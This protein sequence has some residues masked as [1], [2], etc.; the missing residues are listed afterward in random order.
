M[1][2]QGEENC[3]PR[4]QKSAGKTVTGTLFVQFFG[5][6]ATQHQM[7]QLMGQREALPIAWPVPSDNHNRLALNMRSQSIKLLIGIAIDH[8]NA[9]TPGFEH[10]YQRGNGIQP[11]LPGAAH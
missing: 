6:P 1:R 4:K 11:K 3:G 9:N 2:A 10:V 7:P 5:E 8:E